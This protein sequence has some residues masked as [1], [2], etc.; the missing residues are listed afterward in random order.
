MRPP[1]RHWPTI[2][3][4]L[5]GGLA[6]RLG[7]G[8]K[9]LRTIG[10]RTVL[11]RLI[12]RL[13]PSV[14]RVI[15]NANDDP[16]RFEDTWPAGCPR[17]SARQS[18][19]ARGRSRRAGM[20]RAIRALDRMG[21][22]GAWRCTVSAAPIWF[23]RLHAAR[24]R[25][26]MRLACAGSE[27]RTHPV[28]GLWP[29]SHRERASRGCRGCRASAASIASPDVTAAPWNSGRPTRWTR[30]STST[31]PRTLAKPIAS[32]P[33]IRNC[34]GS[35]QHFVRQI[36]DRIARC[37]RCGRFSE[38]HQ[39]TGLR[40]R[41]QDAGAFDA[42]LMALGSPSGPVRCRTRTYSRRPAFFR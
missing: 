23:A 24:R 25:D 20:D 21:G 30:S 19:A 42:M 36:T 9:S 41:C 27:G 26:A 8:D 11:A 37:D 2:G 33:F 29:V 40:Q 18:W 7:G 16:S 1:H 34:D 12:D 6:R 10:G 35:K 32:P 15:I 3:A 4:I 38:F 5:A 22:D 39:A 14:T 17:Q 31:A 13:S 28:I